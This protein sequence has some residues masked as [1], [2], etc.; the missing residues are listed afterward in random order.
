MNAVVERGAITRQDFSGSQT[1]AVVESAANVLAAEA[2]ALVEARFIVAMRQP[3]T[4]DEVRQDLLN[5]CKRPSFANNKSTYYNK[6]VGDGAAGLGIRFAEAAARIMRNLGVDVKQIYEDGEKEIHRVTA[7]DFETNVP[8]SWEINV[9]KTVE[10]YRPLD[11]GTFISCRKNS[12]GKMTYTVPATEDDMLNKR[13]A[14]ISK[15]FRTQVL[16]LV[17]GDIKDECITMILKV[18]EDTAAKDPGAARKA[19]AD[20]FAEINVKVGDLTKYIGHGLDQCSPAELARLRGMYDAIREGE[21][22]WQD[23]V[24]AKEQADEEGGGKTNGGSGGK[25][26]WE[27]SKFAEKLAGW[28]KSIESKRRT[29]DDIIAQAETLAPLTEAQKDQIRGKPAGQSTASST[30]PTGADQPASADLIDGMKAQA[31]AATISTA[32]VLKF[33]SIKSF[34]GITKAQVDKALTFIADPVGAQP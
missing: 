3:R 31:S 9:T 1:T 20:G 17:P 21:S 27:E 19:I 24:D 25:A 6:P 30:T 7:T 22:T 5:E 18:R 10:R 4:W 12:K 33:L 11:D 14:H 32:E 15:A 34:D 2:R 8:L 16:R 13:A 23:F 26:T 29:V 28:R